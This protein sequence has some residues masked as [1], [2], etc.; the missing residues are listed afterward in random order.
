[1]NLCGKHISLRA[2]EPADVELLYKWENDPLIWKVS[3]TLT[4]Y[5]QH[6]LEQYI[7]SA[8]QDIYSARQLRL[9]IQKNEG[10]QAVGAI[11]LFDF[12]P[13]HLRAGIG[14]MIADENERR[15]GHASEAMELLIPYCFDLLHLNQLYCNVAKDNEASI[16]LFMKFG[17]EITGIKKQ[18]VRTAEGFADEF[19]MQLI[20]K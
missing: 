15:N 1:M 19:L 18:W 10:A 17:F 16:K 6:V 3:D 13:R 7:I 5:S 20:P 12:D 2:L 4:P 11:D 9:M 8:A 14:I